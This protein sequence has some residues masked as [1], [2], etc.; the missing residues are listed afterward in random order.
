MSK[1]ILVIDTPE[2]CMECHL[3]TLLMNCGKPTCMGTRNHV[4]S[5]YEKPDW[6]PL[7]PAPKKMVPGNRYIGEEGMQYIKG[8]NDCRNLIL[9]ENPNE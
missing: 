4:H 8:W 5:K 7:K 2:N 1:S 9:G 6:C 3:L